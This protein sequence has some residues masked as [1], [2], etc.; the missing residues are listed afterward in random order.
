MRVKLGRFRR[1]LYLARIGVVAA[2]G[3]T[4]GRFDRRALLSP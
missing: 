2:V 1:L 3:E 4:P